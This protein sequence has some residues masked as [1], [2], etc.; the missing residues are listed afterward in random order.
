MNK[1]NFW[2][3]GHARNNYRLLEVHINKNNRQLLLTLIKMM[4][5]VMIKINL[6]IIVQ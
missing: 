5:V 2:E 1:I 3:W 6:L 4:N